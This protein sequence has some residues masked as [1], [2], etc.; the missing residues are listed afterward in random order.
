MHNPLYYGYK[1]KSEIP[2]ESSTHHF[3]KWN[4]NQFRYFRWIDYYYEQ[5]KN[6][7]GPINKNEKLVN[8][9]TTHVYNEEYFNIIFYTPYYYNR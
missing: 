6:T 1:K 3:C 2:Y 4:I 9:I 5:N 8:H 7:P